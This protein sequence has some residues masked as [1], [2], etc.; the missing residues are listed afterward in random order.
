MHYSFT[1]K[2]DAILQLRPVS[3]SHWI[4]FQGFQL[5]IQYRMDV[6][7]NSNYLGK[8]AVDCLA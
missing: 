8:L 1:L 4:F 6:K 7:L 2:Y 5:A 3:R